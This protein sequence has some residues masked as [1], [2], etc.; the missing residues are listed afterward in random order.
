MNIRTQNVLRK[1]AAGKVERGMESWR[2]ALSKIPGIGKLYQVEAPKIPNDGYP[3]FDERLDYYKTRPRKAAVDDDS[4]FR[5]LY[6][7]LYSS[8]AGRVGAE[9]DARD[10]RIRNPKTLNDYVSSG[11]DR[12]SG[13]VDAYK[14][15]GISDG[16]AA[17]RY[18]Q[19]DT[20]RSEL[21]GK[22]L[23]ERIK[24]SKMKLDR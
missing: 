7:N 16:L 9:V 23:S 14:S 20:K 8:V 4:A 1:I 13:A 21:L 24:T 10:K 2:N 22:L 11:V 17:L 5:Q 18:P 19:G 12:V 15:G 6:D 3:T